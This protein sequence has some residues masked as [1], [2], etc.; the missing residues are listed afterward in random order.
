[1]PERW[2][3]GRAADARPGRQTSSH[4]ALVVAAR[5][6]GG[7]ACLA[8]FR[9]DRDPAL[10]RLDTP[11]PPPPAAVC[12]LVHKDNRSTPRIRATSAA[13]AEAV[14]TFLPD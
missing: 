12:I 14:G 8:R 1:M 9:A 11:T 4:E 13:I 10:T 2:A 3:A 7:L 6:G 5:S